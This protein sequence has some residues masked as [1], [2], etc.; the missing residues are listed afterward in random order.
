MTCGRVWESTFNSLF[1]MRSPPT[2][3]APSWT[4]LLSILYLRCRC[5]DVAKAFEYIRLS[6]LYLRC[7]VLRQNCV[8][9]DSI[10]AFNSLFEMRCRRRAHVRRAHSAFN[11]LF[12]MRS[13]IDSFGSCRRGRLSI[14]YLRCLPSPPCSCPR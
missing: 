10:V 7:G 11:S 14:L 12:E 4:R 5:F 2:P 6:I 13:S 9:P 8:A 1:E 3:G